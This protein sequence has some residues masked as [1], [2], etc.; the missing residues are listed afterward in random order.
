MS[1]SSANYYGGPECRL[2]SFEWFIFTFQRCIRQG[3]ACNCKCRPRRREASCRLSLKPMLFVHL[4]THTSQNI[5]LKPVERNPI[6]TKAALV[7]VRLCFDGTSHSP[8]TPSNNALYMS[9]FSWRLSRRGKRLLVIMPL[10][11]LHSTA[12]KLQRLRFRH[13]NIGVIHTG[14]CLINESVKFVYFYCRFLAF[15]TKK[16]FNGALFRTWRYF[17]MSKAV[18]WTSLQVQCYMNYICWI[19]LLVFEIYTIL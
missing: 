12:A 11:R 1:P 9:L 10:S 3:P 18:M 8:R 19:Y 16:N 5:R 7:L 14:R 13:P 6:R 4:R 17:N 2:M 15:K